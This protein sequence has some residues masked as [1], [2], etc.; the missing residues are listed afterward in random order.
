M[1]TAELSHGRGTLPADA[2]ESIHRIDAQLGRPVQITE[3]GRTRA[4]QMH[5]YNGWISRL[6]GFN[7]ALHPDNPLANHVL[8]NG[9]RGAVDSD[10]Q[11]GV[12]W[13]E[14]GWI[15]TAWDEAWHR[16]YF[17]DRDQHKDDE[18]MAFTDEDRAVLTAIREQLGG[19]NSRKT[20]LREDTD[21]VLRYLSTIEAAVRWIKS[22]LGGSVLKGAKSL[23]DLIR[24]K[25]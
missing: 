17:S 25:K 5:L 19:A 21:K 15:L 22:R 18:D 8:S 6:P 4:R 16:E 2:A 23:T 9:R 10:E 7:R 14:N 11:S 12:P 20:S 24:G 3:A 1:I 13:D